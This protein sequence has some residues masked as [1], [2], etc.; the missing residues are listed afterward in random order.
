[1][2]SKKMQPQKLVSYYAGEG[3]L[4]EMEGWLFF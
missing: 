2:S 4:I 3:Q 1:M